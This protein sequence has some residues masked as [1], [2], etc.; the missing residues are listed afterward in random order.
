[1]V[2]QLIPDRRGLS[3]C[4][5]LAVLSTLALALPS[6]GRAVVNIEGHTPAP[7]PDYDSRASA[8]PTA[9]Q[10]AAATRTRRGCQLE[11]LR[12]GICRQ[13]Q[14]CLHHEG[15]SGVR[16]RLRRTRVARREQGFCSSWTRPPASSPSILAA[17]RSERRTTTRSCSTS[18]PTESHRQTASR[19]SPSSARRTPAGTSRTRRRASPAA[20]PT[21]R[22]RTRS[23]LPLRGPR[24]RIRP[25]STSR[26]STSPRRAPRPAPRRS[27]YAASRRSST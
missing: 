17:A 20:V 2:S 26:S 21:R 19:P 23:R 15:H 16:C 4:A 8:A 13:Q 24:P 7:L 27:P 18:R 5:V 11:P 9:D 10:L 22:A 12:R 25:A 3:L 6:A 14:R 1:M